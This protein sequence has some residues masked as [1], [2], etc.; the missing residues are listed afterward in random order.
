MLKYS[1][2]CEANGMTFG[3]YNPVYLY[4]NINCHLTYILNIGIKSEN[5]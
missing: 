5:K 2:K 3:N 4:A 1:Y